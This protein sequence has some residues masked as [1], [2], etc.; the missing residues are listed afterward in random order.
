MA[1]V[2]SL[3]AW[4]PRRFRS[5]TREQWDVEYTC[6]EWDYLRSVGELARYSVIAGYCRHHKRQ[7]SICDVG[8]GEG[9]LERALRPTYRR[10]LGID[11]SEAAIRRARDSERP[12]SASFECADAL[13]F[14]TAEHFDVIVFNESLYYFPQPNAVLHRYEKYL[15]SEGVFVVSNVIRR[16]SRAARLGIRIAWVA[17]DH[18]YL[19]NAAGARWEVA[20]LG[21]PDR[22]GCTH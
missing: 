13:V 1:R 20:M 21:R 11:V 10:Y 19:R 22:S 6:G 3:I 16:R 15:N 17:L 14:D 7:G 8:C 5:T 12:A 18:T 4:I 9:I 2:D